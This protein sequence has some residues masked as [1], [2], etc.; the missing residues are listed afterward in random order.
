MYHSLMFDPCQIGYVSSKARVCGSSTFRYYGIVSYARAD[1]ARTAYESLNGHTLTLR[2]LGYT[3]TTLQAMSLMG[4]TP[5]SDSDMANQTVGAAN[6]VAKG[7]AASQTMQETTSDGIHPVEVIEFCTAKEMDPNKDE[8]AAAKKKFLESLFDNDS[9]K[10]ESSQ[11][12]VVSKKPVSKSDV[13]QEPSTG[14]Q[15]TGSTPNISSVSD[16]GQ[17]RSAPQLGDRDQSVIQ[18]VLKIIDMDVE[19]N[20][21]TKAFLHSL[22]DDDSDKKEP[23]QA[24]TVSINPVS[25]SGVTQEPST[26]R[27]IT[28]S[29]PNISSIPDP[30]QHRS[31]PQLGDPDHR[32]TRPVL[33]IMDVDTELE[34]GPIMAPSPCMQIEEAGVPTKTDLHES[35]GSQSKEKR[36]PPMRN[37]ARDVLVDPPGQTTRENAKDLP[38]KTQDTVKMEASAGYAAASTGDS[39]GRGNNGGKKTTKG[40]RVT[41]GFSLYPEVSTLF[42]PCFHTQSEYDPVSF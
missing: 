9:N 31:V 18:P 37:L 23:S 38:H 42:L 29:T 6:G 16:P 41:T 12:A 22:F 8:N 30:K 5:P 21:T 19:E 24:G 20:A 40:R 7:P 36:E 33:K 14:Q 32:V 15:I 11:A 10:E 26:G 34:G 4:L 39:G 17:H 1:E 25:K 28:G 27:Q 3:R 35:A 13:A 2:L